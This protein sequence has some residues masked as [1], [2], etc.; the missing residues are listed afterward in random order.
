M[1]W[2][3]AAA[4]A[5]NPHIQWTCGHCPHAAAE[6]EERETVKPEKPD[7]EYIMDSEPDLAEEPGNLVD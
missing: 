3:E 1:I 7:L 5:V 4:K 6:E 2:G